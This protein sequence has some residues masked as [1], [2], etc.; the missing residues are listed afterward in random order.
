MAATGK[1][2]QILLWDRY[3]LESTLILRVHMFSAP[4][5]TKNIF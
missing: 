5:N 4:L 3:I 2:E 1:C